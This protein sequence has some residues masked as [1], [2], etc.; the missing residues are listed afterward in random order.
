MGNAVLPLN[1]AGV[2][3]KATFKTYAGALYVSPPKRT[4]AEVL[5]ASGPLRLRIV[6]LRDIRGEDF[7]TEILDGLTRNSDKATRTAIFSQ[8]VNLTKAL[9]SQRSLKKGDNLT[10]DWVPNVGTSVSLNGQLIADGLADKTFF[11]ALLRV[12]LGDRPAGQTLKVAL[13][14]AKAS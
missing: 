7:G 9:S 6:F 12:W 3:T 10:F 1:G 5:A 8:Q 2:A 13:L 4:T 14:G 11:N